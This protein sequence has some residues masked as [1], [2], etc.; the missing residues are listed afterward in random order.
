[1]FKSN[2]ITFYNDRFTL[3]QLVASLFHPVA[4]CCSIY[5]QRGG[6]ALGEFVLL[7]RTSTQRSLNVDTHVVAFAESHLDT[8]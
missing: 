7:A 6:K 5:V 8:A 3:L 4:I 1:M 2:S